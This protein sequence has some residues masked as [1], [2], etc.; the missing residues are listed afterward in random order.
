MYKELTEKQIM[1]IPIATEIDNLSRAR[2]WLHRNQALLLRHIVGDT[3][4]TSGSNDLKIR[5]R[6]GLQFH[7]HRTYQPVAVLGYDLIIND[8]ERIVLAVDHTPQG[9]SN[10]HASSAERSRL[11]RMANPD[12]RTYMMQGLLSMVAGNEGIAAI[13]V[14]S[15]ENHTKVRTGQIEIETAIHKIDNVVLPLEFEYEFYKGEKDGNLWYRMN[16]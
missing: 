1:T 9:A 11:C 15:A 3:L 4:R 7:D 12:F 6:Y 16:K 14:T 5:G 8:D 10:G 2:E 13:R